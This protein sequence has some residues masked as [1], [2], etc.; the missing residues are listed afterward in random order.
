MG[1]MRLRVYM[2]F[3]LKPITRGLTTPNHSGVKWKKG[4]PL[5]YLEE[6]SKAEALTAAEA[7]ATCDEA[8]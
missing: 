8:K 1:V 2:R 5:Q 4:L 3:A 6:R 7:E